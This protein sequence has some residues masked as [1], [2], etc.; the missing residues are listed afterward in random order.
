VDAVAEAFGTAGGPAIALLAEQGADQRLADP[1]A[2]AY[3]TLG[4]GE[5]VGGAV[6]AEQVG[7]GQGPRI[8]SIRLDPACPGRVHRGEVGVSNDDLMPEPLETAGDPLAVGR[9][10]DQDARP[11]SPTEHGG[12]ALGLGADALLDQFAPLGQ[13]TDLTSPLVDVDAN[14]IHGWPFLSRALTSCSLFWGG[15]GERVK[16]SYPPRRAVPLGPAALRRG[17]RK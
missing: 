6:G 7:I 5:P 1:E 15:V 12:E 3:L 17:A 11:G 13:D 8:A 14:M 4:V 2:A 9:G 10:L 16:T